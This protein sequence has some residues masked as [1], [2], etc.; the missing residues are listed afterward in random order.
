M[1]FVSPYQRFCLER[2]AYDPKAGQAAFHYSFD[3]IRTFTER[4]ELQPAPDYDV[5][6]FDRAMQLAHVLIGISYY[7]TFLAPDIEVRSFEPDTA[8]ADFYSAVYRDGLSQY[9][10]EN[11]L[12]P[13]QIARFAATY[14]GTKDP[15]RYQGRGNLVLQSGGKDSLLLARLLK[16]HGHSFDAFY[17]SS[18]GHYPGVI[19]DISAEAVHLA[20]RRLDSAALTLALQEDGL[21]GHVPVTFIV[22]SIAFLQAILLTKST[23][24][25]AVGQEGEEP[26]ATIGDYA[27]R[28]QWSKTWQ[29][30]RMLAD[31]L[32]GMT[33]G[34]LGVG[35][36]LRGYSEL[37]IA[38]DFTQH[39]WNDFAGKFSSCNV[40]NYQQ[41]KD[42]SV[43]TWCGRCPKCANSFLLFAPWVEPAE[44][45]AVF[46]SNL[47]DEPALT[48]DFRGLLGIGDSIK[49]FECVGE[50]DELRAAYHA[51]RE[52]YPLANYELPFDVPVS[53]FDI[54]RTGPVQPW[55]A[56]M[57]Q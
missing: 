11:A 23:V 3:G 37:R 48:E 13:D 10:Y 20:N 1:T 18:T 31:H 47:F 14:K 40:A 34:G 21:N 29:A 46:G 28:H 30:E 24:L 9:I 54:T 35:S 33:A 52:N 38:R 27:V 15:V 19:D 8:E 4:I 25:M 26:H 22:L 41:G 56:E 53:T 17:S 39:C 36:P 42:N 16:A 50:T 32:S 12:N 51:A 2:Y 57:I 45:V 6:A 49:P 55:A 5:Q 43:L 44:L 7:K